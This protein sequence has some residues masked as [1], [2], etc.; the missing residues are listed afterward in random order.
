MPGIVAHVQRALR[1]AFAA[2][3]GGDLAGLR[4]A[5][6]AH[7]D[8]VLA[9]RDARRWSPL[10]AAARKGQAACVELLLAAGAACDVA[11]DNCVQPLYLAA[12]HGHTTCVELLLRGGASVDGKYEANGATP[13]LA[14]AGGGHAACVEVLLRAGAGKE[15]RDARGWTPLLAAA[16]G[17]H[18]VV[19]EMLSRAGADVDSCTP[20]GCSALMLAAGKGRREV[21]AAL[22]RHGAKKELRDSS[23][24]TALLLAV[25][26]GRRACVEELLRAGADKDARNHANATPLYVAASRH[27]TECVLAL[28]AAG[29][30][31]RA[32]PLNGRTALYEAATNGD[33]QSVAAL[34]EAGADKEERIAGDAPRDKALPLSRALVAESVVIL[35]RRGPAAAAAALRDQVRS[36]YDARQGPGWTALHG[37]AYWDKKRGVAALLR[38]GASVDARTPEGWTALEL[39]VVRGS[40]ECVTQLL[41]GDA[42][43]FDERGLVLESS[44][45]AVVLQLLLAAERARLKLALVACSVRASPLYARFAASRFFDPHVWRVVWRCMRL[46]A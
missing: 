11:G 13:L 2:A 16:R 21:V 7:R 31:V 42:W 25:E 3:A 32:R 24:C 14:A 15:A 34:L 19:V 10:P 8:E 39:A 36:I 17:G 20:D 35:G 12:E 46:R 22:L 30:D 18:D 9:A 38:A 23:G 45:P 4:R 40:A 27:K 26:S 1:L 29:A 44:R 6:T 33:G 28:L 5:L 43:P 41:A 37:A